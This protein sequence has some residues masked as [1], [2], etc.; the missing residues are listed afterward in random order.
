MSLPHGR[1]IIYRGDNIYLGG[2][3][4][5][6]I[7]PFMFCQYL[8]CWFRLFLPQFRGSIYLFPLRKLHSLCAN[9][10]FSYVVAPPI[11]RGMIWSIVN[12]C[13]D[14][15]GLLHNAHTIPCFAI[16][17][18]RIYCKCRRSAIAIPYWTRE[19]VLYFFG[20]S[21]Y[22]VV[23][24]LDSLRKLFYEFDCLVCAETYFGR[25]SGGVI[26]FLPILLFL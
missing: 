8:F 12:S 20:I 2:V 10:Q 7:I 18:W 17:C 25:D 4:L 26:Y 21:K 14:S 24:K 1:R 9:W 16:N 23:V 13:S 5:Y 11:A 3:C 6:V 19:P 15:I 22:L